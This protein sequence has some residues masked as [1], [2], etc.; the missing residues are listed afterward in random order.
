M[1]LTRSQVDEI[2]QLSGTNQRNIYIVFHFGLM[3]LIL[4]IKIL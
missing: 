1:I 3:E 4:T 2:K